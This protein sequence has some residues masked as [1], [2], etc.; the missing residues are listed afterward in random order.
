M[1]RDSGTFTTSYDAFP[2]QR[3]TRHGENHDDKD[4]ESSSPA[5]TCSNNAQRRNLMPLSLL[6]IIV[7]LAILIPSPLTALTTKKAG[8]LEQNVMPLSP[9]TSTTSTTKDDADT[10]DWQSVADQALQSLN[11]NNANLIRQG[12]GSSSSKKQQQIQ[13]QSCASTVLLIRH[14][15]DHGPY[16]VDD[17]E[18]GNKHCSHLGYQR[19]QHFAALF[20]QEEH[21]ARQWPRPRPNGLFALLPRQPHG[22]NFRQIEMLLPL[23]QVIPNATIHIVGD[24]SHVASAI[25]S[26]LQKSSMSYD[27]DDDDDT[28]D[29]RNHH[30]NMCG[31]VSV[32]AWKHAFI[33]QVAASLGCGPKQGCPGV[34]PDDTFD[35]MW[36]LQFVW[37]PSTKPLVEVMTLQRENSSLFSDDYGLF[38]LLE[39]TAIRD[40]IKVSR[41]GAGWKVYGTVVHQ[42]FDPLQRKTAITARSNVVP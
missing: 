34:Y 12:A 26:S 35:L 22:V 19:A 31:Q 7:G 41:H 30:N 13:Q 4:D 36:M 10:M 20:G 17:Q 14:C 39:R 3:R 8:A 9:L 37:E 24:P 40:D 28:G 1:V 5:P 2:P 25:F 38:Q 21:D 11:N 18:L 42:F 6:V 29:E 15:D 32:V 27:D 16:A 23:A 33:P